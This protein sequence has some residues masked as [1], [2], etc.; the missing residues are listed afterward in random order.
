[1]PDMY[2][3]GRHVVYWSKENLDDLIK[4][5]F[6][7]LDNAEEREKIAAEGHK[8]VHENY[9]YIDRCRKLLEIAGR[10]LAS[11]NLTAA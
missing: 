9:R 4:K 11:V 5:I 6:Y 8:M 7:Y 1:M 3:D 2:I 10:E